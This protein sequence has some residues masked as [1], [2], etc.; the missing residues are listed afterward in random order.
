MIFKVKNYLFWKLFFNLNQVDL[1][2]NYIS[3]SNNIIELY[4]SESISISESYQS[5]SIS[6]RDHLIKFLTNIKVN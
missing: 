2:D 4:P 6:I 3:E 5:E 1:I